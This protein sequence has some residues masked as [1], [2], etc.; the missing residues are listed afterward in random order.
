MDPRRKITLGDMIESSCM[1]I[2]VVGY[3][4]VYLFKANGK[5]MLDSVRD[6]VACKKK[7]RKL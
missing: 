2:I 4:G 3:V 1:T 6:S 5:M 7:K